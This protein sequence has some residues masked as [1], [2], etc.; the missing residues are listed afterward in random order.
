MCAYRSA[1]AGDSQRAAWRKSIA[2]RED[3][4]VEPR[5]LSL[6]PDDRVEGLLPDDSIVRLR[7]SK[8]SLRRP[9]QW[10]APASLREAASAKAGWL[11]LHLWE[12]PHFF[13]GVDVP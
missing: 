4:A 7:L 3:G 8:L 2:V 12:E 9:R 13:S 11:A 1:E 5:T 6:F 10:G